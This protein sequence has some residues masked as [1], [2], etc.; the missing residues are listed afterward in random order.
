[1]AMLMVVM[2]TAAVTV[3]VA[4]M[5]MVMVMVMAMM[6]VRMMLLLMML[7]LMVLLLLLLLLGHHLLLHHQLL[8]NQLLLQL[9]LFQPLLLL[10]VGK[11]RRGGSRGEGDPAVELHQLSQ[12]DEPLVAGPSQHEVGREV[13]ST[14]PLEHLLGLEGSLDLTLG[15]EVGPG[16]PGLSLRRT[17]NYRRLLWLD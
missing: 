15:V 12:R 2:P 7:L 5:V 17:G 14:V 10:G 3:A 4:V 16:E 11:R 1:M 8:L 6:M 9:L 13:A